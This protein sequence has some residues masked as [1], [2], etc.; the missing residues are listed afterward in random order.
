[1]RSTPTAALEV[2]L[3]LQ[4][5]NLFIEKEAMRTTYRLQKLGKLKITKYGHSNFFSKLTRVAPITLAPSDRIIA[6][7]VFDRNFLTKFPTKDSWMNQL[8]QTKPNEG[9]I[10]YTDGSYCDGKAGAGI[11]S[12]NENVGEHFALGT[13]TTVFQA[14]LFAILHCAINCSDKNII[15]S[16]ISNA[17]I[18]KN[19]C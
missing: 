19:L 6:T 13:Y 17:Q 16:K 15:N 9:Y 2:A 7:R 14:E 12:E 3:M 1:M 18:A 10:F 11:Y 4:P 8:E 5:L